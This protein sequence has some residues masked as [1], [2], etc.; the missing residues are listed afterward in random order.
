MI[1]SPGNSSECELADADTTSDGVVNIL[2]VIQII[3]IVLGD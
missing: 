3:N 1:L 2:D